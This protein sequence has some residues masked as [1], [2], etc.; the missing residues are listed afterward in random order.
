MAKIPEWNTI[1]FLRTENNA[2]Y[3]I[4][5]HA[6]ELC[7]VKYRKYVSFKKSIMFKEKKISISYNYYSR[8][9]KLFMILIDLLGIWLN[10]EL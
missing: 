10:L 5:H 3:T 1:T 9:K 8:K 7:K 4:F 6:E 2:G